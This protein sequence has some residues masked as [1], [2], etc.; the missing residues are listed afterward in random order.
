M[1][2]KIRNWFRENQAWSRPDVLLITELYWH[3]IRLNEHCTVTG[4]S[5]GLDGI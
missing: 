1:F 5:D 2:F 3:F 4:L